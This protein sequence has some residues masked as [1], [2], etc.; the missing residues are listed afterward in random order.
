MQKQQVSSNPKASPFEYKYTNFRRNTEYRKRYKLEI[1]RRIG[2]LN[3]RRDRLE[4]ELNSINAA[5]DKLNRQLNTDTQ[6]T[7]L[8]L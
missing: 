2:V 8:S 7:Q 4:H 3:Y 5:L 6:E 1:D